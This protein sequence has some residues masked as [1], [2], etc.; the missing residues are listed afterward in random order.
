MQPGAKNTFFGGRIYSS[1]HTEYDRDEE[2]LDL[3]QGP[4]PLPRAVY[5]GFEM[6]FLY[7]A[8]VLDTVCDQK[9]QTKK[10]NSTGPLHGRGQ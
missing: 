3:S 8:D 5:G 4:H 9:S 7:G 6:S 10:T 2:Y 1:T